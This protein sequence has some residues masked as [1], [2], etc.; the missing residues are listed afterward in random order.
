MF[1]SIPGSTLCHTSQ[2]EAHLMNFLKCLL[3]SHRLLRHPDSLS[4][5]P[6][7]C[8][9]PGRQ[10]NE[11]LSS[12]LIGVGEIRVAIVTGREGSFKILSL[13]WVLTLS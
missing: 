2:E 6:P 3:L 5:P 4:T 10:M 9:A 7:P 13:L 12:P 1:P 11:T 8:Q